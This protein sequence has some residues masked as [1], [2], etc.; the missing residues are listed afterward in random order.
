MLHQH[1]FTNFSEFFG[2]V[3]GYTIAYREGI[4]RFALVRA[5]AFS[6]FSVNVRN[7][8]WLSTTVGLV[9]A[10]LFL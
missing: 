7:Y 8:V 6:H 1:R 3:I 4:F 2:T 9:G 5:L 10:L